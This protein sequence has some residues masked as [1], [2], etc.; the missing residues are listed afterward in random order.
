MKKILLLSLILL[1][2]CVP[3]EK[4]KITPIL[5]KYE[6]NIK[7]ADTYINRGYY[8]SLQ[9]AFQIYQN[10]YSIPSLRKMVAK[11][12]IRVSLLVNLREKELG[13]INE[14]YIN[15]AYQ[16]IKENSFLRNFLPYV[17]II[18]FL[19]AKVEGVLEDIGKRK[20]SWKIF[21]KKLEK[22]QEKIKEKAKKDIFFAYLWAELQCSRFLKE[23]GDISVLLKYYPN[24]LLIKYKL[25]ICR[26]PNPGI[27]NEIIKIEPC[28]Y[29]IYLY[30]G[31]SAFTRKKFFDAEENFLRAFEEIPNSISLNISLASIY[32]YFEEFEKSIEYYNRC[33]H[34]APRY[35]DALLGKAISLSYLERYEEAISVLEKLISLGKW[36]LGET[37][38]WLAWNK[39]RLGLLEE[40]W[41][42]IEKAKKYL[43]TSSEVYTLSGI[44]AFEKN[45]LN[46]AEK[47]LK[48]ALVFEPSNAEALFNLGNVYAK[49]EQWGESGIYFEKASKAYETLE[50]FIKKRITKIKG[51]PLSRERKNRIIKKLEKKLKKILLLKATSFYNASAG[52]FNAGDKNK[53][54]IFA[55]KAMQHPVFKEKAEDIIS[56]IKR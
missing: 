13:I 17:E 29:E 12:L 25:A 51:S 42:D 8:S 31:K 21:Y 9:K 34:L 40:A 4:P 54:L 15:R 5:L 43:P 49:K 44:L 35:R 45:N 46:K 26:E 52:Y 1:S 30:L 47:D 53:A 6:K 55:E 23:K 27:L 18:D 24:S 11:K 39:H 7:E 48:K 41:L 50:N 2:F 32:F 56:K 33:L 20:F 36:Y 3:R 10:L 38:Y 14:S 19:D 37:N 22:V 16:L 28:F